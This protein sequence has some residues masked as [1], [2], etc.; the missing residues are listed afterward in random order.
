MLPHRPD[1][2]ERGKFI[3]DEDFERRRREEAK[4]SI[5]AGIPGMEVR[6][7]YTERIRTVSESHPDPWDGGEGHGSGPDM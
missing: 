3:V 6:D 2:H 5:E 4:L 7:L 1:R